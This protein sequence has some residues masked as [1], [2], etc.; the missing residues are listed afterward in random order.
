M[1]QFYICYCY[2]PL[3]QGIQNAM[4]HALNARTSITHLF[5]HILETIST[6]TI[7]KMAGHL[8]PVFIALD[9]QESHITLTIMIT[10]MIIDLQQDHKDQ[11]LTDDQ[12]DQT[13]I[14]SHQSKTP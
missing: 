8:L 3:P 12:I 7:M 11:V 6:M 13:L 2:Q 5:D 10:I 1:L 4:T 14:S 9:P